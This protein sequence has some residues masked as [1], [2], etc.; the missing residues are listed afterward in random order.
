SCRG[1]ERNIIGA[2]VAVHH[3]AVERPPG[4]S[5]ERLTKCGGGH[6]RVGVDECEHRPHVGGN[7]PRTLCDPADR[8]VLAP[9]ERVFLGDIS[10]HEGWGGTH[11]GFSASGEVRG[12]PFALVPYE[13][14]VEVARYHSGTGH[15]HLFRGDVHHLCTDL[16]HLRGIPVA[17]GPCVCI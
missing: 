2:H 6:L 12:D 4:C 1:A 5:L 14:K 13:G 16:G 17:P 3:H 9:D 10:C 15:S 7:H 8:E 11:L